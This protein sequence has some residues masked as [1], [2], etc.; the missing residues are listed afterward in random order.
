[1]KFLTLVFLTIMISTCAIFAQEITSTS[2]FVVSWSPDSKYLTFTKM[3]MTRSATPDKSKPPVV[4]ADVYTMKA[5]G[6]EVKKITGDEQNEFA[7]SWSKN[8]LIYFGTTLQGSKEG[9]IFAVKPD[10]TGLTQI[11]KNIGRSSNPDVS[12][13]G[14]KIAFNVETVEHKPQIYTMNAD[15]SNVKAL[16]SDDTLAFYN[17]VWSPDGKKIVYYVEK[18]DQKDQIWTMNPDGTNQTLLTGNVAHN[19]Y[20]SWSADG[21]RIIFCS[22]R[23]GEDQV[24]YSMNPDGLDIKRLMKT[25]SPNARYSP[26]G[27]KIVFTAG[28]F[29]NVNIFVANADGTNEV[30]LTQ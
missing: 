7:P 29:P 11:T 28:K 6:T 30:K 8:K 5:D 17:P 4:K 25:N 19:F 23:D 13:D 21:K 3:Q 20:P 12:R 27:K 24:I 1:M 2:Y 14:K 10:R 15:G 18:G 22:N 9:E 16:T 26:D